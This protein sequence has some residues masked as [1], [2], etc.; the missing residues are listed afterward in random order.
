MKVIKPSLIDDSDITVSTVQIDPLPEWS[1]GVSYSVGNAST[2]IPSEYRN[3]VKKSTFQD[4]NLGGWSASAGVS[5][6]AKT[7]KELRLGGTYAKFSQVLTVTPLETLYIAFTVNSEFSEIPGKFGIR[8]AASTQVSDTIGVNFVEGRTPQNGYFTGSITVP[9]GITSVNPVIYIPDVVGKSRPRYVSFLDLCI[10]RNPDFSNNLLTK[11]DF[12]DGTAGG[13]SFTNPYYVADCTA[14]KAA[15][16]QGCIAITT[17]KYLAEEGNIFSV[18]QGETVHVK[19]DVKASTGS[20][21][22]F[23][24]KYLSKSGAIIGQDVKFGSSFAAGSWTSVGGNL[25]VPTNA[26]FARPYLY[27]APSNGTAYVNNIYIGRKSYLTDG[28]LVKR[29]SLNTVYQCVVA[30]VSTVAPELDPNNWVPVMATNEWAAFDREP[31]T[32]STAFGSLS[33]TL[34]LN[35]ADSL[36]LFGVKC[37]SAVVSVINSS[38]STVYGPKTFGA[39]PVVLTDLPATVT[40]NKVIITLTGTGQVSL[41]LVDIGTAVDLG[42]TDYGATFTIVDY[43]RKEVDEFGTASF[44]KRGFAKKISAKS[45]FA[46]TEL[47]KIT[48]TLSELRATPCSWSITDEV[49]LETMNIFG[50]YEDLDINIPYPKHSYCSVNIQG[51]IE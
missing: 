17:F 30:G 5:S 36:A 28:P 16:T 26:V 1:S 3:L 8:S 43:S 38:G 39:N 9:A 44:V 34:K 15:E 23:G 50:W 18:Y 47:N 35:G 41:G 19:A 32:A 6:T 48:S 37:D 46:N 51:L 4:G 14:Y 33:V 27:V 42:G 40:T 20:T 7:I 45:M 31:E 22:F 12:N 24:V 2:S 21:A 49:G 29:S 10:S 25:V 13:G 11:K